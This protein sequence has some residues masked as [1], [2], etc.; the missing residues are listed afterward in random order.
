MTRTLDSETVLKPAYFAHFVV[1]VRDL[2]ASLAWYETVLGV[3]T[4]NRNQV[5]AFATYDDEHHRIALAET[6]VKELPPPNSPGVDHVA[7]TFRDLGE[8]LGHYV[9]LKK[10]GILPVWKIN[11]GPTTSLYYADPDGN[12]VEFQ[13]DNF[14]TPEEL[15]GWMAS[16]TF[17]K[18]PIGVEFDPDKLVAR[19]EQGDPIEELIQQGSA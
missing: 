4:V 1:R 7:Y 8:L 11:H 14:A 16:D 5:I 9:R 17:K 13:V 10:A 19:Y 12:R 15:K 6:P 3:Q 18:N 2:E